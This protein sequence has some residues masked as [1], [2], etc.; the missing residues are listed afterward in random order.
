MTPKLTKA[1]IA[2]MNVKIYPRCL[3]QNQRKPPAYSASGWILPCCWADNKD[4]AGFEKLVQDHL[5]LENVDSLDDIFFSDEWDEFFH[6]LIE[7][8]IMA[9]RVCKVKCCTKI[10]FKVK[11]GT[12]KR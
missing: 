4:W 10:P 12:K 7:N 2:K 6:N 8:P 9:P 3:D 11:H 5:K 1:E